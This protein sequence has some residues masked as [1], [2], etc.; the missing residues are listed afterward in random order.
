MEGDEEDLDMSEAKEFRGVA[1]R[2]SYLSFGLPRSSFFVKG[3]FFDIFSFSVR[4][5][6]K[7]NISN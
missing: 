3:G 6:E 4:A 1:G 2:M 7:G 5:R